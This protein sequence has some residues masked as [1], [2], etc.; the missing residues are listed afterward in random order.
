[1]KTSIVIKGLSIKIEGQAEINLEEFKAEGEMG[2]E[3]FV[4]YASMLG[5]VLK[6]IKF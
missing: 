3:E 2:S 4:S 6:D 5:S 1:M